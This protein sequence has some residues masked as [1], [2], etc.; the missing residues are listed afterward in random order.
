M[1][2][3]YEGDNEPPGSLKAICEGEG[4]DDS[5]STTY[6][7]IISWF[8]ATLVIASMMTRTELA[9]W[10]V[11]VMEMLLMRIIE[12]SSKFK[13]KRVTANDVV[14]FK[15][16]WRKFYKLSSMSYSSYGRG[17]PK[18]KKHETMPELRELATYWVAANQKRCRAPLPDIKALD[19]RARRQGKKNA[20]ALTA[21]S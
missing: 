5:A 18:D 8:T 14:N 4:E 15:A 12:N 2:G 1:A 11:Q 17:V 16:W 6:E 20:L 9:R 7:N 3:L 19:A 10:L 21:M 13:V